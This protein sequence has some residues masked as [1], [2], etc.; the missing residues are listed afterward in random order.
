MIRGG[1]LL[2][3]GDPWG[4][5]GTPGDPWGPL[6]THQQAS[7][8]R[9]RGCH[10]LRSQQMYRNLHSGIRYTGHEGRVADPTLPWAQDCRL[11]RP[12]RAATCHAPRFRRLT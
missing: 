12:G 9:A 6:R 3:E 4:P 2:Q 10:Q 5:L 8:A 7:V 1:A 11:H